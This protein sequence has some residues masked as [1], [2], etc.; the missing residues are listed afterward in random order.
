ME[1]RGALSGS[2]ST[3]ALSGASVKTESRECAAQILPRCGAL[4]VKRKEARRFM[5]MMENDSMKSKCMSRPWK[6][7]LSMLVSGFVLVTAVGALE[8]SGMSL[9]M[10]KAGLM[11]DPTVFK[12]KVK[13]A[14]APYDNDGMDNFW[15]VRVDPFNS[16]RDASSESLL[17]YVKKD[18]DAGRTV[19]EVLKDGA[20]HAA[21]VRLRHSK[22]ERGRI[23]CVMDAIEMQ[24][25]KVASEVTAKFT[26]T[27]IAIVKSREYH[28]VQGKIGLA[29]RTN[30]KFFKKPVL[31]VVLLTEENGTR[32]VRDCIIDEP[33]IK[34]VNAS[35]SIDNYT[36]TNGN[37]NN[38]PP[39]N[40]RYIEEV[41]ASQSEVSREKYGNITYVGVPLGRQERRN[42]NG[43]KDVP[44][45]GYARFDRDEKATMLGYR[46]ELWYNGACVSTYDT[47]KSMQLNRLSL[48]DD[49]HVS[50]EHPE[51]FK[52]RAPCSNKNV[53]R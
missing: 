46:I 4:L 23:C 25:M 33:N 53:T 5:S 36:T 50:F 16:R 43:Y 9:A 11:T 38:E 31:R 1:T 24:V 13:I 8:P 28:Y 6:L 49:W 45:F 18:S 52:Y 26:M 35:D 37:E 10:F 7:L 32:V 41:S 21:F 47:I 15:A 30:L 48:P 27:R 42:F 19:A 39:Y 3:M 17:C 51:K 29:L 12:V 40:R 20:Y 22:N 14:S 34:M 2:V 44:I